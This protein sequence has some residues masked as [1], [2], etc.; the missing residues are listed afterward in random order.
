MNMPIL[1]W[2][3][4]IAAL[5]VGV[6]F[7]SSVIIVSIVDDLLLANFVIPGDNEALADD[8]EANRKV[9]VFAAIGYILVL[10]LDSIIALALYVVLKPAN[11][12]YA[13]LLSVLRLLYAILLIFSL[14]AMLFQLID[15]YNYATLKLIGYI[16]FA[17]HILVL[18]YA[19]FKSRYIPRS[20]GV[21]L[22]LASITYI[23]FFIDLHL[24]DSVLILI[25]LIMA[26]AEL[27]LSIW[28]ILR[29]NTLP[30]LVT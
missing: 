21:L 27:S 6:A 22:M 10:T 28:L 24:S 5:A 19:V 18:G 15:A 9:F 4:N 17:A 16:F 7:I 8:I 2:P 13:L 3:I 26:I 25:M 23:T 20:L 1:N 29:R 30:K 14:I 11:K 12:N